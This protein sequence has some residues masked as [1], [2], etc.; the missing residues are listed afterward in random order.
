MRSSAYQSRKALI[1]GNG[2][3][4]DLED[5]EV[6][7]LGILSVKEVYKNSWFKKPGRLVDPQLRVTQ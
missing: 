3:E 1:W 5:V 2:S 7:I 4:I 6:L